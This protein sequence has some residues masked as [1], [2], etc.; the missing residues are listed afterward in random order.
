MKPCASYTV[1]LKRVTPF[2]FS[3]SEFFNCLNLIEEK[4][5]SSHLYRQHDAFRD[6]LIFGLL[7][8][9]LRYRAIGNEPIQIGIN[10]RSTNIV[11]FTGQ[12]PYVIGQCIEVRSDW[13]VRNG[14]AQL[15][16]TR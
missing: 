4:E 9:L 14:Q 6:Q 5:P 1:H 12:R 11:G 8:F 13:S 3:S 16:A 2:P 7:V 15:Q 10:E